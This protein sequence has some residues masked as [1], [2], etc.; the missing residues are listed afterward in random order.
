MVVDFIDAWSA[1]T[2]IPQATFIRWVGVSRGKF[3]DWKQRYGK[4]NEHN[5]KV[6]RDHWLEKWEQQA[7][8]AY[9][10][11]NP[12]EGYRRMTFMMLDEDVVAVSP[13]SVYRVLSAA[14]LLDRWNQKPSKKGTGF[15]QPLGA[16]EHW[17]V[18]IAYLNIAGTFYYLCSILDG[19][20]R[21]ILS[22]GASTALLAMWNVDQESSREFFRTFYRQ[23]RLHGRG[24]KWRALHAAQREFLH[25]AREAWRHPYHWAPYFMIGDWRSE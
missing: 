15:E 2:E 7:I 13:A 21:A 18:D 9:H 14:G 6:P 23:Y 10:R 12:L 17:H 8:L 19:F 24:A 4:L 5:G 11:A 25:S 3:F 20:S 16:H 1:K 22:A